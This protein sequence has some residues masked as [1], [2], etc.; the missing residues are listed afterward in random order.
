MVEPLTEVHTASFQNKRQCLTW[1][2]FIAVN[3]VVS[4]VMAAII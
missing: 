3:I 4:S 1:D 2:H